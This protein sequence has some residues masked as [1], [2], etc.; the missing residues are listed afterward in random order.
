[1]S[2]RRR[3][4]YASALQRVF[5]RLITGKDGASDARLRESEKRLGMPLPPALRDY[6]LVAGLASENREHNRLFLPEELLVEG[7]HLVFME[8]N[9]AVVH[10]GLPLAAARRADPI[11]WQRVNGG[12]PQ[13]F[14]EELPFSEFILKNLAWQRGLA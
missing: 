4:R 14:S 2:D 1:M 8:E 6:F 11:V 5:R 10:W 3:R 7:G 13:W 12:R 9:Q